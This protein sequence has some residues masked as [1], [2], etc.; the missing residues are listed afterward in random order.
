MHCACE[1]FT[2]VNTLAREIDEILWHPPLLVDVGCVCG[3]GVGW[4][5]GAR[6]KV[7]RK[8]KYRYQGKD[9]GGGECVCVGGREENSR[10]RL[11]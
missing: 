2:E 7:E 1:K 8:T 6:Y 3:G 11:L 4:G 10:K 5:S 9:D